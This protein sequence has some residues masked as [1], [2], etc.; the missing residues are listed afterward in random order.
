MTDWHINRSA[1]AVGL[2]VILLT[3]C[4]VFVKDAHADTGDSNVVM[5]SYSCAVHVHSKISSYGRYSLPEL[6]DL[7]RGYGIDVIFLT[8]NRTDTIQYGLLPFRHIFWLNYSR[9]SVI[10]AGAQAYLDMIEAENRRQSDVLYVPGIEIC[11]RFYWTGTVFR[12]PVCHD[13]QKNL[14]VLGAVDAGTISR[15]REA[16]GYIWPDDA[17]WI[18][19][20][21][22]IVLLMVMAIVGYLFLSPFLAGM[23]SCS[24][25]QI[26]RSI[27]KGMILP[28]L[29]IM[30]VF[31]ICAG[32]VSSFD[33][34]GAK[35]VKAYGQSMIDFLNSH[36]LPH[37]W[38]HPEA[39]DDSQFEYSFCG[40]KTSFRA[41][42]DPH[43]E[44][45]DITSGYTGFG[46]VYEDRNALIEAGAG[47]DRLLNEYL[48][49]MRSEPVWAFGEMLY[50]YEGQAGKKLGNVQTVVWSDGKQ[51]ASI[52]ESIRKGRFYA[53]RNYED[54]ALSLDR[55]E[56]I[57]RSNGAPEVVAIAV[58][59]RI[60]GEPIRIQVISNGKVIR[61]ISEET[62]AEVEIKDDAEPSFYGPRYYR[63]IVRGRSS[64]KLVSNPVFRDE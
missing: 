57:S 27:L 56:L 40:F 34:Y 1:P 38:A 32:L 6:T 54:Q 28:V 37:Y 58:S 59:S 10:T 44:I 2:L 9:S 11:P 51:S 62:P 13:H 46:G 25:R 16:C 30:V 39:F 14:I 50:H 35:D 63:V 31:N 55:F 5:K 26:R 41:H 15:M 49:G 21:R 48:A 43:P 20:S 61:D 29:T 24:V 12:N 8:D 47:W 52:L 7:A 3:C 22:L 53:R 18:I 36:N 4:A 23:M 33:I 42:T 19:G 60:A 45:L 17:G 64:L